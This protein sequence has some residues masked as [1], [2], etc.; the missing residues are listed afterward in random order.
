VHTN[1]ESRRLWTKPTATTIIDLGVVFIPAGPDDVRLS[2]LIRA[3][4]NSHPVEISTNGTHGTLVLIEA[5]D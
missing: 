4:S 1:I 2:W 5:A 3:C